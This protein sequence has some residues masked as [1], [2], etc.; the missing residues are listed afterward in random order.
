MKNEQQE[1][2]IQIKRQ[3]FLCLYC[4]QITGSFFT[5]AQNLHRTDKRLVLNEVVI[6]AYEYSDTLPDFGGTESL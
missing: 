5:E 2:R 3:T 4:T 6:R 1:Q